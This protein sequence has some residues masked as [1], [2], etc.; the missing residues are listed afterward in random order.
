MSTLCALRLPPNYDSLA[1]SRSIDIIDCLQLPHTI[2]WHNI[3]TTQEAFEAIKSM[4][5]RGAPAIAS[6]A[7]VAI[8]CE[9][10]NILDGDSENVLQDQATLAAWLKQ[11]AEYL[12]SSRPTAVNL[13]EAMHRLQHIVQASEPQ[14]TR[15]RAQKI[16]DAAELVWTEDV[17]RNQSIGDNGAKWLMDRLEK[18]GAIEAGESINVLTVCNT[19]SLATSGYGTALGVISSLHRMKRLAHAFY[20]QTGPYQQGARLTS[21]ELQSQGIP[22]TMVIDTAMASLLSGNSHKRNIHAFILG[23][24][25]IAANGDTANKISSYQIALLA[26]HVPPPSGKTRTQTLVCAPVATFDLNMDSGK[27]IVIEERPSWEACTVRGKIYHPASNAKPATSEATALS[28]SKE[29][30]QHKEEVVTVLVTPEGTQAWNPAFDV[31]PAAIID[32][33]ACELGVAEKSSEGE[34]FDLRQYVKKRKA[35]DADLEES[36]REFKKADA[37]GGANGVKNA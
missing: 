9:L 27:S 8:A 7:A 36:S 11:R 12:L 19:G 20:A 22:S 21:L 31:T 10:M 33:I 15:E 2:Q 28:E 17:E 3:K 32:G 16:V 30:A 6:L 35:S 14:D 26:R 5:I 18:Q 34:T 4:K 13:R 24:D 1:A 25:R 29:Q 37:A 23:A